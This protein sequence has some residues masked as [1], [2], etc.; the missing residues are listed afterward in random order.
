MDPDVRTHIVKSITTPRVPA[1]Y[2][3]S[4]PL[5]SKPHKVNLHDISL[6]DFMVSLNNNVNVED[7]EVVEEIDTEDV[8]TYEPPNDQ[9]FIQAEKSSK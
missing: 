9:L 1:K 8:A 4:K 2:T 7:K 3:Y 5:Y 6:H